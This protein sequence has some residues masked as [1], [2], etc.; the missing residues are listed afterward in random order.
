MP[1]GGHFFDGS[2]CV[3]VISVEGLIGNILCVKFGQ[4]WTS[5]LS[6]HF[7]QIVDAGH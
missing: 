2:N 3:L 4:I 5:G 1:P 7:K 6:C